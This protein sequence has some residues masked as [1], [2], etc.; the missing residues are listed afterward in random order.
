[1]VERILPKNKIYGHAQL[2]RATRQRFLMRW[3]KSSGNTNWRLRP[4]IC[5]PNPVLKKSKSSRLRL[6]LPSCGGCAAHDRPRYSV[7]Y[8]FRADVSRQDPVSATYKRPSEGGSSQP[9]VEAYFQTAWQEAAAPRQT[10]PIALDMGSLYEQML[11][12]HMAASPLALRSRAGEMLAEMVERGNRIRTKR[13]ERQ[14][15]ETRLKHEVQFNRKVEINAA[16]RQ[17]CR[18]LAN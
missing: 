16:L 4:S 12:E 9:V 7:V 14:R 8:F 17:C 1:M 2:N 3:I 11:R 13:R 18:E 10:L 5:R 6:G 15:L